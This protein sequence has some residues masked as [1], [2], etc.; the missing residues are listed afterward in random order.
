MMSSSPH[1]Q[2]AQPTVVR[3]DMWDN[4]ASNLYNKVGLPTTPFRTDCAETVASVHET[5]V[6]K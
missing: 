5:P 1:P 2:V 6:K 4:P 3:Y